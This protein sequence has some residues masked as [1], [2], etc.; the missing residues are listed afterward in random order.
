[1][2]INLDKP[3]VTPKASVQDVYPKAYATQAQEG[4]G[5]KNSRDERDF[6]CQ[7]WRLHS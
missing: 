2:S 3:K 5:E 7:K 6:L 1:M 4:D